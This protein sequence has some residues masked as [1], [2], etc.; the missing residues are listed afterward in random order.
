MKTHPM[1]FCMVAIALLTTTM[2]EAE[3]YYLSTQG[4]DT[5]PGNEQEPFATLQH[6]L[7]QLGPGD[8]LYVR[9]GIYYEDS[10]VTNI[11]GTEGAPILIQAYPGEKVVFDASFPDYSQVPNNEWE[12]VDVGNHIYRTKRKHNG[13][14]PAAWL[15]D[16]DT[17]YNNVQYAPFDVRTITYQT[18]SEL[19]SSACADYYYIGPGIAEDDSGYI[20][21]RMEQCPGDLVNEYGNPVDPIP[22]NT[23]PNQVPIAIS[24]STFIL[25]LNDAAYVEINN[26]DFIH[27]TNMTDWYHEPDGRFECGYQP[28]IQSIGNIDICNGSHHITIKNAEITFGNVGITVNGNNIAN[29]FEFENCFDLHIE[30]C[31][32]SQ[33]MP[34]WMVWRDVKGGPKQAWP[35]F[36][37]FA[38]TGELIISTFNDNMIHHTLDGLYIKNG[39]VNSQ[40][41]GNYFWWTRDDAINFES[42]V[43]NLEVC[44]NILRHVYEGISIVGYPYPQGANGGINGD[45]YIHHNVIDVIRLMRRY[46]EGGPIWD[47]GKVFGSHSCNSTVGNSCEHNPPRFGTGGECKKGWTVYN[48]TIIARERINKQNQ[49]LYPTGCKYF[50]NNIVYCTDDLAYPGCG[51]CDGNVFWRRSGSCSN[52]DPSGFCIDPG[53]FIDEL[54]GNDYSADAHEFYM[55]TNPQILTPGVSLPSSWPEF[56]N[57]YRGAFGT[58]R[59][60]GCL[61]PDSLG[62]RDIATSNAVLYWSKVDSAVDYDIRYREKMSAAWTDCTNISDNLIQLTGLLM[63]TTYEWEIRSSSSMGHS[64]YKT[65]P[66]FTTLI[67]SSLQFVS[68]VADDSSASEEGQD[69]GSFTLHRN[70]TEGELTVYL[71]ISGTAS[72]EDIVETLPDSLIFND[73][74]SMIRMIV[75]PVDD[76]KLENKETIEITIKKTQTYNRSVPYSAVIEIADNDIPGLSMIFIEESGEVVMEAEHFHENRSRFDPDLYVWSKSCQTPGYVGD[77]YITVPQGGGQATW[78]AGCEVDYQIKFSTTGSYNVWLRRYAPNGG[79]NSVWVGLDGTQSTNQGNDNQPDSFEKWIWIN[80]DRIEVPT[81]GLHTFQVRRREDGYQLDRIF[82]CISQDEPTGDGPA[83][84]LQ[85]I[86]TSIKGDSPLA[87]PTQFTLFQNY[88]NPFNATTEIRYQL[89][90]K[91]QVNLVVYDLKGHTVQILING[92]QLA[93]AYLVDWNGRDYSGVQVSSGIYICKLEAGQFKKSVKLM[94]LK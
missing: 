3:I 9:A 25:S 90:F 60:S 82:M 13:G 24:K 49:N 77:G 18:M 54:I 89:P 61:A 45:I 41:R 52:P 58:L 55:P 1:I 6:S 10:V 78:S 30:G 5:F 8:L 93:G 19:Q 67:D 71:D 15:I 85:Q 26:I 64:I 40:V 35:E 16:A 76:I 94:L 2:A 74:D 43:D 28:F 62:V 59:A 21:I 83:E 14:W 57:E 7:S 72:S 29:N 68:I 79:M 31:H 36:N 34:D 4:N 56:Q 92:N 11:K 66:D 47:P 27:A 33:G 75:T 80:I 44:W 88:P 39:T 38:F 37:S 51:Y 81:N 69:P 32:I 91:S 73:G 12:L 42:Y 20:Y 50:K 53:F 48:N 84:S 87:T 17:R 46:R 22:S 23:D 65:G 70:Q 86:Y 63:N